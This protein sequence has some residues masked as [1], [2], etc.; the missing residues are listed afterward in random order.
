MAERKKRL[1]QPFA[2]RII[3][4]FTLMTFV[5]SSVMSLSLFYAV[6]FLEEELVSR[7]L[8]KTLDRILNEDLSESKA[9]SL[10]SDTWFFASDRLE[11]AIP[12]QFAQMKPGFSEWEAGDEAYY[13]YI[14]ETGGQRYILM[15]DQHEFERHENTLFNLL[16]AGFLLTVVGAWGLGRLTAKRVMAPISRLAQEVR[17]RE[18]LSAS[19]SPMAEHYANDEIGRLAEAFDA[20]LQRLGEA[21]ERER[22]F[23]S[24]VSHELRTPLMIIA[25]SCELLAAD[26]LP[27]RE[28]EQI[29]RIARAAEEMRSLAEIFLMLARGSENSGQKPEDS[30]GT[31][32]AIAEEQY[33][34][35]LPAMQAKGLEFGMRA[36]STPQ[37]TP[38]NAVLLRAVLGNLLR[39]AW[40]Y[41]EQGWV[42]LTL[43]AGGF[44][45]EDSGIGIPEQEKEQVFQAFTRGAQARGEGLGLGLSLVRRICVSQG[46]KITLDSLPEGG[47]CFC[48]RLD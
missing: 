20:S 10:N 47:S 26:D 45:V 39:N 16:F 4:A 34:R 27:P 17:Q 35:W 5:V 48:V 44:K 13:M 32:T 12:E 21:L 23:T 6:H 31:L 25:T 3:I 37:T 7:A 38:L 46:W 24:D 1:R 11:Y 9:P 36:E 19:A 8:D 29:E 14:R 30:A 22:L 41:T 42:R 28:R 15:Q 43:E 18:S 40:H 33:A 2:R